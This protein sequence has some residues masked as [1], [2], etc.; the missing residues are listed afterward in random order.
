VRTAAAEGL[1]LLDAYARWLS[2]YGNLLRDLVSSRLDDAIP[3]DREAVLGLLNGERRI[4]QG[5]LRRL[6]SRGLFVI[7][8]SGAARLYRPL[9]HLAPAQAAANVESFAVPPL[10]LRMFRR[11]S[12]SIDGREIPWV[13][14]RD[15]QIIKYL[16]LKTSGKASREELASIFWRDVDRHLATQSV[17]TVCSN[18][19]KA[20]ASIVGYSMVDQYFRTEPQL[21]LEMRNVACDYHRFLA[22]LNDGE[23]A[24]ERADMAAAERHYRTAE[25]MYSG[26]LL[27]FD[28]IDSWAEPYVHLTEERYVR[29]LERLA[30]TALAQ[31][32]SEDARQWQERADHS[33]ARATARVS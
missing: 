20:I 9:M 4:D 28:G 19:R 8:D 30:G 1:S 6:E 17:R 31:G 2:E 18:I 3:E 33:R 27:D 11:F 24:F 21:Q 26:R 23:A 10:E 32:K 16:L 13:R 7:N 15:Q 22:H 14:R 12:A 29:V 25:G 5:R